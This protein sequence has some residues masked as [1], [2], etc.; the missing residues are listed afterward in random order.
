MINL[1]IVWAGII[2][3]AVAAYVVM[4]GFDL[5]IGILFPRFA[6]G[7]DR[8]M[9]MNSIAP[10][11][12]GNETWLVMGGGGLL[13]AF[14]LAYAIVLPALYAPLIAM[15]LGLV[16]RGVAFEF[17][18]RDPAHRR[19]W[20]FSFSAGSIVATLAQGI[21]LGALLQGITVEGRAYAGGWWEWLSPFSIATGVS[22]LI[23]Y[24]LLG[25]CWLIWKTEGPLHD[26]ARRIAKPLLPALLVAI[27][28]VSAWT[29]FLEGQYYRR[30][31][32]WPGVLASAQMPL[33][34]AVTGFLA[35]RAILKGRDWTPFFLTL[36][37]FGLSMIGLAISIWPDVIPGRVS[38]WEAAAPERSQV[39]MLIGAA[40]LVPV[41][42]AYTVWA[43]WVFRGKV[44]ETGYH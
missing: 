15:L 24:A 3:F 2:A 23:G 10:V 4:D 42:L 38:I 39:F 17:R 29:P 44:D 33:L 25:A 5:G 28:V 22:L 26:Q 35:W 13:A 41:I 30:W 6:V 12:D 43:Y 8:D 20:D 40:V 16:F 32:E 31:F 11:W 36:A 7:R 18:W 34:V 19:F 37:L 21:T 27:A 14:P 1:T 9:A